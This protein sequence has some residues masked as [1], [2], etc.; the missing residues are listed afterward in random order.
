M[1]LSRIQEELERQGIV[2]TYE[3][4]AVFVMFV[5]EEG[6]VERLGLDKSLDVCPTKIS[7]NKMEPR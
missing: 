7:N 3:N 2:P 1:K 5:V 4:V 6:L